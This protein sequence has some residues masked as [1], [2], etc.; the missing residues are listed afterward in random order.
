[1]SRSMCEWL[2]QTKVICGAQNASL[3]FGVDEARR[4]ETK[5]IDNLVK[6][7]EL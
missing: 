7:T 6:L 1:M 2:L 3:L 4:E 5:T